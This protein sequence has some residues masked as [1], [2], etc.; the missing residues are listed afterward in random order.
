MKIVERV[1]QLENHQRVS[2]VVFVVRLV[3]IIIFFVRIKMIVL[4]NICRKCGFEYIGLKD[5]FCVNCDPD[6]VRTERKISTTH[7]SEGGE[8]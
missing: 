6:S 5:K 8:I 1:T 4:I 7:A 3:K 2:Q